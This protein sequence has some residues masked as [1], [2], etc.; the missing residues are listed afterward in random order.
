MALVN[1]LSSLNIKPG[2]KVLNNELGFKE[3]NIRAICDVGKSTKS[4]H[5]FGYIG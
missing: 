3:K 1:W 4:K 2:V 5:T